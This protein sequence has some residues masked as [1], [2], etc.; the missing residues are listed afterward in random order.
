MTDYQS[1]HARFKQAYD[2]LLTI[3]ADYPPERR[4]LSGAC[5]TWSVKQ[6]L[7][8]CSGWIREA[9]TRYEASLAGDTSRP[10]YDFDAFNAASVE[11]RAALDW[12]ATITDLQNTLNELYSKSAEHPVMTWWMDVLA[13]DCEDHTQQIEAFKA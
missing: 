1:A 3:L 9:I 2:K 7:A 6:I 11:S 8:H 12:D 4:E 10:R 5:G 13:H